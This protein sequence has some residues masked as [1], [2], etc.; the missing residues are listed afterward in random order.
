M[1]E[2]LAYESQGIAMDQSKSQ[3]N[4]TNNDHNQGRGMNGKG[5]IQRIH[6]PNSPAV[7]SLAL[8]SFP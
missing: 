7:H 5:I 4:Q 8:T 3:P 2:A 6:F 1:S